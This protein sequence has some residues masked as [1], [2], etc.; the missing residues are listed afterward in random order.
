MCYILCNNNVFYIV[1]ANVPHRENV[2][3]FLLDDEMH[4][5]F[6]KML[7]YKNVMKDVIKMLRGY[8]G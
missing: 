2:V 1:I 7:C 5:L 4:H 8:R 3:I 6:I